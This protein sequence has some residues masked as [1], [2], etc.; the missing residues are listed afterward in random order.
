MSRG[1]GLHPTVNEHH[2]VAGFGIDTV[3]AE[4]IEQEGIHG[5]TAP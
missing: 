4:Q 3:R 1:A 2:A 5:Q